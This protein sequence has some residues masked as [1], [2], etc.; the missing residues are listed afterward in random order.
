VDVPSDSAAL[1]R[2]LRAQEDPSTGFEAALREVRA[3][4]KRGHWIWYILPQI[5]GLGES[6]MSRAYAIRD[7]DEA[8]AYL[9]HPVLG[10]RLVSIA[11]AVLEQLRLGVP[12]ARLMGS[13]IDVLKLVSSMTLFGEVARQCTAAGEHVEA[14]GMAAIADGILERARQSGIPPC[15]FTLERLRRGQH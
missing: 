11:A 9:R 10:P 6:A 5:S 14:A 4:G 2:Y 15:A 7:V 8:R 1:E 3:G 12:L 13:S